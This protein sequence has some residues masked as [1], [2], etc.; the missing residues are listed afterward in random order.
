[1]KRNPTLAVL[2]LT[3][4]A[5]ITACGSPAAAGPDT[6]AGATSVT[7]ATATAAVPSVPSLPDN[8]GWVGITR[9][10][11]GL[12][13]PGVLDAPA[14]AHS[15][16]DVAG[17]LSQA[18]GTRVAYWQGDL[19]SSAAGCQWADINTATGQTLE[20]QRYSV[21]IGYGGATGDRTLLDS[22]LQQSLEPCSV[23]DAPTGQPGSALTR[24]IQP[25]SDGSG[26]IAQV[27]YAW[28]VPDDAGT[29]FWQLGVTV[30]TQ[31]PGDP[32]QLATAGLAAVTQIA[33]AAF[34]AR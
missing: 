5:V 30:G 8:P 18:M 10:A 17:P 1:V 11:A 22:V 33:A 15:C 2:A 27:T 31:Y 20:E 24:C 25:S 29:G 9:Q 28:Y 3:A 6:Q 13:T 34:G 26:G 32:D 19:T 16:P 23:I 21:A 12:G 14:D 7:A 4:G